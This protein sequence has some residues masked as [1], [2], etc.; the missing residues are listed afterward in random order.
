QAP[1]TVPNQ[2]V[3]MDWQRQWERLR[4]PSVW[5]AAGMV[6]FVAA[7]AAVG[8][9]H[10]GTQSGTRRAATA[11]S[12]L[13]PVHSA[14]PGTSTGAPTGAVGT[15]L[16]G[17]TATQEATAG[18][19][20]SAGGSAGSGAATTAG[21]SQAGPAATSPSALPAGLGQARVVR[22]AQLQVE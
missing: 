16:V 13:Q 20:G 5:V 1:A 12:G 19:A 2:E 10:G 8:L 14:G 7:G 15:P 17:R 6:A 9:G 18:V 21:D 3:A 4:R 22:T 11:S